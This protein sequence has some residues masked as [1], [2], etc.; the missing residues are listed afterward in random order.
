MT[1]R[2]LLH[3]N[4][5]VVKD[6][7]VGALGELTENDALRESRSKIHFLLNTGANQ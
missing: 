5:G 4:R 1:M 7:C 2:I 3:V 6:K